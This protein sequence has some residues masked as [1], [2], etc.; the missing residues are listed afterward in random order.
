M[1]LKKNNIDKQTLAKYASWSIRIAKSVA[2]IFGIIFS[3]LKLKGIDYSIILN[4]LKPNI[5]LRIS[6]IVL[7]TSWLYGVIIDAKIQEKIYQ[8][9]NITKNNITLG[10]LVIT[11]QILLFLILCILTNNLKIFLIVLFISWIY[12]LLFYFIFT[13]YLA[14]D[15][16][17]KNEQIY[18]KDGNFYL[19]ERYNIGYNFLYGNWYIKRYVFGLLILIIN[20]IIYHSLLFGFLSQHHR[21]VLCALL[22]LIFILITEIWIWLERIKRTTKLNYIQTIDNKYR[23]KQIKKTSEQN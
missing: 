18:L 3:W 2:L 11:P 21:N 8:V 15:T 19:I 7:Y 9:S 23:I 22:A 20:I 14:K 13:R 10:I 1:S 4:E 17:K 16:D 6:L 12:N 5:I